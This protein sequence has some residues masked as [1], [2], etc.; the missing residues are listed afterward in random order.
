MDIKRHSNPRRLKFTSKDFK[1]ELEAPTQ[2]SETNSERHP[3][4]ITSEL[5]TEDPDL[6]GDNMLQMGSLSLSDRIQKIQ[7]GQNRILRSLNIKCDIPIG[8]SK[9]Q[10]ERASLISKII[11]QNDLEKVLSNT[12][13][14]QKLQI[15][16]SAK[17]FK[18][19]LCKN[20]ENQ[21]FCRFGNSVN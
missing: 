1:F 17:K 2:A 15:E 12:K 16:D 9:S 20:F 21:G 5:K 7:T 10:K 6:S 11:K 4:S 19:E 8:K 18:T 14:K 13:I 3:L